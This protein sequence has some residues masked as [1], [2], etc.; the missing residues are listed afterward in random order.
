[1]KDD[2]TAFPYNA[3]DG[4]SQPSGSSTA[5]GLKRQLGASQQAVQNWAREFSSQLKLAQTA[6]NSFQAASGQA[7]SELAT[8]MTKSVANSQ[9]YSQSI[10]EQM[11]KALK[12]TL[13]AITGESVVRALYNTGLGFYYLAVQAY[14]QAAQAFEAAAIFGSIAGVAGSVSEGVAGTSVAH[15]SRSV[16]GTSS[17]SASGSGFSAGASQP[18]AAA[19]GNVTVMVM[20][21][22]QAARWLTKVINNGVERQDM[23]LVASHTRRPA[24]AAR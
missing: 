3:I 17:L 18:N 21:E 13:A 10:G 14:G 5:D 22:T 2:K 12:S 24:P 7:F 20:G 4:T 9:A 1:M 8:G 23:R 16:N 6:V 19:V 15:S 11:A